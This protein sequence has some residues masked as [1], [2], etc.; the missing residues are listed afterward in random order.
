MLVKNLEIPQL[1]NSWQLGPTLFFPLI[2]TSHW[3]PYF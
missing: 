2:I 3:F 1:M